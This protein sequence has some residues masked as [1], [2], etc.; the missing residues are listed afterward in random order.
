M[1]RPTKGQKT[2][3]SGRQKGTPNRATASVKAALEEA[4]DR[5]GGVDSLIAWGSQDE[6]RAEFYK[7]WVK[8]LNTTYAAPTN[9]IS[10]SVQNQLLDPSKL[11]SD[12]LDLYERL[13]K[14]QIGLQ[15]TESGGPS[16][17]PASPGE[18]A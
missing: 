17:H 1:P 16:P 7:L 3:G 18:S 15:G 14:R 11:T 6:N 10:V 4:F 8:I 9:N 13:A 2:A 12:E 5:M